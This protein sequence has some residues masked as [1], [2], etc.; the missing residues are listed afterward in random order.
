MPLLNTATK[1]YKGTTPVTKIYKGSV[2][3]WSSAGVP[4]A[5]VPSDLTGLASWYDADDAS[6]FSYSSGSVVSQWRDKSGLSRHLAQATVS[7]QPSRSGVQNSRTT[8]LFDGTD[9]Y[10]DTAAF[11]LNQPFMVFIALDFNSQGNQGIFSSVGG[12]YQ[13]WV[14]AHRLGHYA[15]TTMELASD[16]YQGAHVWRFVDN[17]TSSSY[18]KDEVLMISGNLGTSGTTT[19]WRIAERNL[20]AG[21]RFKGELFEIVVYSRI[22]NSTEISQVA[23]YLKNKWGTP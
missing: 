7:L 16:L 22:L 5:F 13:T 2:Q 1:V 9:D 12:N 17:S 11:T 8:V 23:T 6:T 10:L 15:G 14:G 20:T 21:Y 4:P 18:Y 19:G 3:V